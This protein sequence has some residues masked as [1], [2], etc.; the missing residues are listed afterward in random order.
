MQLVSLSLTA[1]PNQ[2]GFTLLELLIA[3]TLLG[4]IVVMMAGALQLGTRALD[5][6]DERVES[7]NR[8][9]LVQSFIRRQLSQ[10]RPLQWEQ[11]TGEQFVAF[12]G[13]PH[14][15]RFAA[16]PPARHLWGGL[17]IIGLEAEQ[18]DAGE[19]LILT[20]RMYV[21]Q[22]GESQE[23]EQGERVVLLDNMDELEFAYLGSQG[24]DEPLVWQDHW[25][26]AYGFPKLVRL[27]AKMRDAR[28]G[29]WPELVVALHGG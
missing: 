10:A 8:I 13:N 12:E 19:R 21:Q 3:M 4:F 23:T 26:R 17:Q 27:R 28:G 24:P 29:G 15:M 11:A 5:A 16:P 2:R 18:G 1:N 22:A 20:S 14:A 9:R 7:A 25:Q 6:G